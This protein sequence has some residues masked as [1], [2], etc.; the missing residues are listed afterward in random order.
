MSRNLR[1]IVLSPTINI[2]KA[3]EPVKKLFTIHA[4]PLAIG[5]EIPTMGLIPSQ[6]PDR[7]T[8]NAKPLPT[9]HLICTHPFEWLEIHPDGSAFCCCPA[10][11]KHPLGNLL[12][13]SVASIWNGPVARE[14]RKT[15]HNGS[16]HLCSRKRCPR[17]AA[18]TDPVTPFGNLVDGDLKQ[19]IAQGCSTLPYGPKRLNLC[20]DKSCNLA[21]PSCRN[22]VQ[23]AS[24]EEKERAATLAAKILAEAAPQAEEVRLS[25]Y[26]DP[27]ASAAYR[28]ILQ[29][30]GPGS[31][32]K[33]QKIHL[34]CNGLLWDEATWQRLANI[35][36]YVRTAEIS[37][38]A[39]DAATY[40]ENRGGDFD[41]LR[42]NLAFISTL[43]ID[44]KISFV[45]QSNNYR[46]IPAFVLL[47]ERFGFAV[48]FSQLV[49]WGTF[50]RPE[51]LQRAVHLPEHPEHHLFLGAL[52]AVSNL[53]G[54]DVGNLLP[55]QT[56]P[57]R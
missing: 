15:I 12:H 9:D 55:L 1:N 37:V 54:V 11:L 39:A 24:D 8:M 46:Q 51:F 21:C 2:S 10:W 3:P 49:N 17:L 6:P 20:F 36:P 32:P 16:F 50:S 38:D 53:A 43:P 5:A 14:I 34:H 26:G 30:V 27:F 40:E 23:T 4:T 31:F 25:G 48:Y 19:A 57:C 42:R 28:S 22:K 56:R 47:A 45:V 41:R 7:K 52:K 18:G 44:T 13:E 29:A 35:H 33:L